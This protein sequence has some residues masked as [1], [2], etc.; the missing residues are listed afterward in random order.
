MEHIKQVKQIVFSPINPEEFVKQSVCEVT[1]Y[2]LYDKHKTPK[3][4]GINDPRMGPIDNDILCETCKNDTTKCP[5]HF[6]HIKLSTPVY[7]ILFLNKVKKILTVVCNTCSHLIIDR[8]NTKLITNLLKTPKEQRLQKLLKYNSVNNID[9]CY[10]CSRFQ[11]KFIKDG[12]SLFKSIK[13]EGEEKRSVY[14]AKDA[15]EVLKHISDEDINFL[16]MDSKNAR[17]EWLLFEVFPVIPPCI[18]PSVNFGNN[19][20]S[21]DDMVY[22]LM[23]IVK[24]NNL[25]ATALTSRK[26]Y[27]D[28]Y[29]EQLQWNI[30]TLIDNSIAGVPVAQHRSNSRPLKSLKERIKGK[31]GRIR[32]N[33]LGKR[34]NYSARTVVGPDPCIAIDQVGIPYKICKILTFPEVVNYYNIKKLEGYVKNGQD[35]YPGVNYITKKING[36]QRLINV[37]FRNK[38]KIKLNYGDI[39]HRH[40]LVDDYVIFNRQPSLHKMSMQGHRVKPTIGK[41]FRLN[42]AVCNPYN[43][44]FDGDEM[45]V[46]VPQTYQAMM[47]VA[48]IASVPNQIISPQ[49]N[50]PIIGCIMDNIVGSM[51]MTLPDQYVSEEYLYN[52]VLKLPQFSGVLPQPDKVDMNG[53][54][55]WHGRSLMSKILPNINYF[56]KGS[57]ENVEVVN[58]NLVSGTFNKGIVGASSGG[59][60]HMIAND[61][62]NIEAKNFIDNIQQ[63]TNRYLKF[64]GFSVGY[65]DV[66]KG[67]Q[68]TE[69]ITSTINATKIDVKKYIKGVYDKK[70]KISQEDFEGYIFNALN[71][72]RDDI[73]SLVMKTIDKKNSFYEMISSKAKG[74]LLNISQ[75]LGSV[76]QQNTQWNGKSGRVPLICNNR[77][78]PYFYQNDSSPEARG[79]IEH[80]YLDGLEVTEFFFHMQAGREGIIDTA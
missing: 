63:L 14:H 46:F 49:S 54:K 23:D 31:E 5:G 64:H 60:I 27:I 33:I 68:I 41:S 20:R 21:E 70:T 15:L 28:D 13:N 6:G 45:N 74:S 8:E 52:I 38:D 36:Q 59:L 55:F 61:L 71:K 65:G 1:H 75:I 47:E 2:D 37:S 30:S 4:D 24:S 50:S 42:P 16:G 76:G 32:G 11:P 35:I 3:Y 44:D 17:P 80:S 53:K 34:V 39:V 56:K 67:K 12:I 40:L 66:K 79:F 73:G 57:S 7:N 58:G 25:L 10:E 62:N 9:I 72:A 26:K 19:L 69:K 29:I 43:A 77:S 51:I 48:N 18:R 22:K 78:L